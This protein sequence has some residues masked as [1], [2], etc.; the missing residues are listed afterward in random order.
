VKRAG[1]LVCVVAL[2]IL[3]PRSAAAREPGPDAASRA[4]AEAWFR[5]GLE[6]AKASDHEQARAS[7]AA[8]YALVPS[9][10]ILWNLATSE[11]RAGR[12]VD[13]L[14]HLRE[15]VALPGAR[16]DR[17][18]VAR[19]RIAELETQV[20][21]VTIDAPDGAEVKIDGKVEHG[22]VE[23]LPGVHAV[24]VSD[25]ARSKS[26]VV[27]IEAGREANVRVALDDD[28][29]AERAAAP[30]VVASAAPA[31]LAPPFVLARPLPA[32]S[33]SSRTWATLGLAGG[34]V[35]AI[36]GGTVLAFAASGAHDDVSRLQTEKDQSGASCSRNAS[37]CDR[38]DGARAS[39]QR[40]DAGSTGLFVVGGVLGGA[41]IA[42]WILWPQGT[43]P[44][45]DVVATPRGGSVQLR[46]TF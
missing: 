10:D 45:A 46:A 30:V 3:S 37:L 36:A 29:K 43:G 42:S 27:A 41:A 17:I 33:G 44:R 21:R 15:Y 13:A 6:R 20:G 35:L 39:A 19:D 5:S 12:P 4:R 22:A 8:A 2:G 31:P 1:S 23:L 34:A 9:V 26:T 38:I 25:G 16:A 14:R 18:S 11:S 28:G 32:P 40:M 7:F 24:T